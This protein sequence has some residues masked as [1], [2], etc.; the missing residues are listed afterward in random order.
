M[1]RINLKKALSK[2]QDI[3]H[4]TLQID[5]RLPH[6]IEQVDHVACDYQIERKEDYYVLQMETKA[7]VDVCCQRCLKSFQY[8]YQHQQTLACCL[9]DASADRLM[10]QY[11]CIVVPDGF[12]HLIDIITDDLHL[13]VPEKHPDSNQCLA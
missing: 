3:Q 7:L 2:A 11:D 6:H 4:A 10:K 8:A 13:N 1:S 9:D 12:I 5:E